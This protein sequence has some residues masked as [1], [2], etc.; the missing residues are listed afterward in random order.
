M[1]TMENI[2]MEN[3]SDSDKNNNKISSVDNK[4]LIQMI[5]ITDKIKVRIDE[6]KLNQVKVK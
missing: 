6:I 5:D 2:P 1:K 4:I 3:C